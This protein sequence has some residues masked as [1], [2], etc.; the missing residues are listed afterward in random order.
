MTSSFPDRRHLFHVFPTF[1]VGGS[2][3]R[4]AQIANHFAAQYRHT[5]VTLDGK[6]EARARVQGD[7]ELTIRAIA[8]DKTRGLANLPLF[9]RELRRARPDLLLT[10]NWGAIEWAMANRIATRRRH[11]HIED[12]FGPE[13]AGGQLKRRATVR[14]LAV[15]GRCTTI[16]LPSQT[17]QRIALGTWRL[18]PAKILYIPNGIDCR[19]FADATPMQITSLPGSG[20][21]VG[22]V[23]A[24]RAEKNLA[25]LLRVFAQASAARKARLLIVGDGPERG[26]LEALARQLGIA[27]RTFFAGALAAPEHALRAMDIF[28]ISSDTE[29]M[30]Y[31]VIEAMAAARPVVGTDVGDIAAMVAAEN[32]KFIVA[33]DDEARLAAVLGEMLGNAGSRANIGAANQARAR[34]QFEQAAMFTAYARLFG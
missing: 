31:G 3:I 26:A 34:E 22:T 33:R 13:E 24:L 21:I 5:V 28:A 30:P 25:R 4:F 11:I 6:F 23:A 29:Q 7:V 27:N 9:A 2:Q 15:G 32:R 16:V 1:A 10:Y 12:G 17:L 20:P 14:R 19:R 18:K 8:F